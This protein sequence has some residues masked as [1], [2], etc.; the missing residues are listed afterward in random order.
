MAQAAV[1]A[2]LLE[3][4]I[5]FSFGIHDSVGRPAYAGT[6]PNPVATCRQGPAV[7]VTFDDSSK[8]WYFSG[9][10]AAYKQAL[11]AGTHPPHRTFL[12][13]PPIVPTQGLSR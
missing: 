10:L 3:S 7:E 1:T 2:R 5:T 8:S 6:M 9:K 12:T 11:Q 13:A 4:P